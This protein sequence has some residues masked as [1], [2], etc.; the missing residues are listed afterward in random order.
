MLVELKVWKEKD[1]I[2]VRNDE[3]HINTFGENLDDALKNFYDAFLLSIEEL[4]DLKQKESVDI[5]KV[6]L[7]INCPATKLKSIILQHKNS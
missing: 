2:L 6:N 1:K 7:V 3:F 5:K 4:K